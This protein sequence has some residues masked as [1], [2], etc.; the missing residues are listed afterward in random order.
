MIK[1]HSLDVMSYFLTSEEVT[2]NSLMKAFT[3][4]EQ[5]VN[6]ELDHINSLLGDTVIV[7]KRNHL[8]FD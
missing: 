7:R 2:L 5:E 4:S 3:M 6:D 8:I 1:T